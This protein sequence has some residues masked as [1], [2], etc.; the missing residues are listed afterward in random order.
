MPAL[1]PALSPLDELRLSEIEARAYRRTLEP[2]PAPGLG[3]DAVELDAAITA[4]I[5]RLEVAPAD[6]HAPL[7]SVRRALERELA[8]VIGL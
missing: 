4:I 8:H 5:D 3:L 1:S 6:E 2:P 7:R